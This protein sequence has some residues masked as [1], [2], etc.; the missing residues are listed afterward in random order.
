[1]N[2]QAQEEPGLI[3]AGQATGSMLS[4]GGTLRLRMRSM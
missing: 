4:A 3:K 1:M 2:E